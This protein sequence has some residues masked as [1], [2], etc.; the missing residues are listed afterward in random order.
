ML[1]S[2]NAFLDTRNQNLS[3]LLSKDILSTLRCDIIKGKY[4]RGQKLTEQRVCS[5]YNVS[6]TPVREAFYKL[7]AEGLIE[8]VPNKGAFV[9]GVSGQDIRDLFELRKLY[10]VQAV[11][12]AIER[13]TDAELD[14]LSET[15]EFMEFY[16]S[17]NDIEKMANINMNFHQIIYIASHNTMLR[18]ILS[19]YQLYLQ[20]TNQDLITS[21]YYLSLL[22]FE[23]REIYDAFIEK[24]VAA[25]AA[26]AIKHL[27]NSFKRYYNIQG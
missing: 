26:A 23:H 14:T 7:E 27:D 24:D 18:N 8:T 6:R 3:M 21:N 4:R 10:E 11:K 17:Y 16:T 2:K 5:D 25:G 9:I 12:W 13:I 19:S 1:V 20:H 22:L 15:F